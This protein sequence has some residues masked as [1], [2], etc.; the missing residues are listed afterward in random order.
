[1]TWNACIAIHCHA[2]YLPHSFPLPCTPR[3]YQ[4]FRLSFCRLFP[5][6]D[7][8]LAWLGIRNWWPLHSVGLAKLIVLVC[9]SLGYQ[10]CLLFLLLWVHHPNRRLFSVCGIYYIPNRLWNHCK[11]AAKLLDYHPTSICVEIK[12]LFP[13]LEK[14]LLT[15]VRT[16]CIDS[17]SKVT[18][19][20]LWISRLRPKKWKPKW[21]RSYC[22][23]SKSHT[24]GQ[25][26]IWYR[27]FNWIYRK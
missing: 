8:N 12:I 9:R 1:M 19:S 25:V 27:T 24:K 11:T 21:I 10:R 3:E 26:L 17:Y 6:S 16:I 2:S 22:M 4:S 18:K 14:V 23:M 20:V 7:P 15:S 13:M 5:L